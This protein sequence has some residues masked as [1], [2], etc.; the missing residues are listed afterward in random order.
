VLTGSSGPAFTVEADLEG[1]AGQV[2]LRGEFDL[3]AASALEEMLALALGKASGDIVLQMGEV[4]F[5]DC[6]CVR[7]ITQAAQSL[8]RPRRL[9]VQSISPVARRLFQLTGLDA[10]RVEPDCGHPSWV[11]RHEPS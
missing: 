7:V 8:P 2:V 5:I 11:C 6:A 10:M 9:V 3:T 4:D 1:A